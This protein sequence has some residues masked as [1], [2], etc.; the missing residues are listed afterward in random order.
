MRR[1]KKSLAL[2]LVVA[3]V[4]TSIPVSAAPTRAGSYTNSWFGNFW[5]N[6]FNWNWNNNWNDSSDDEV[7]EEPETEV[8]E[9]QELVVVEDATT[10]EN[11]DMLRASTYSLETA[12][13]SEAAA[14]YAVATAAEEGTTDDT[15]EDST[16]LKYFPVTMY[17]YDQATINNAT[18]QVEVDSGKE[19]TEWEGI[20]FS[21]GSPVA[22]SY[23]TGSS[24]KVIP[25]F[26]ED[27]NAVIEDG[28][29]L[30]VSRQ[31]NYIAIGSDSGIAASPNW[32]KDAL[33]HI[34]RTNNE[35]TIQNAAGHY[36]VI[37]GYGTRKCKT[38]ENSNNKIS[39]VRFS[40]DGS[41][42][43]AIMLKSGSFFLKQW[44]G[45]TGKNFGGSLSA[46]D[47]G[48]VFYL[49]KIIEDY[50]TTDV[51]PYA[52]WN[53][54]NKNSGD[55]NNGQKIYSG[56]AESKLDPNKDIVFTKPDG[57]IFNSDASVKNI[58]TNVEM[59][60]VY[61]NGTYT[62]DASKNGVYFH[63]DETQGSSGK[64]ASNTRLYF[65]KNTP[66]WHYGMNYGDGSTNMWIPFNDGIAIHQADVDYHFGMRTTI[67]FSMTENGRM[68]VNDPES[69]PIQF[70]FSGDDDVWV[71]IDGQLVADLGG[72][73]NRLDA[74]IDF[75]ANTITLS[76]DN[77]AKTTVNGV[78]QNVPFGDYNNS[79]TAVDTDGD[80]VV[81]SYTT[82]LFT[83]AEGIGVITQDIKTFAA[84]TSHE[85]TIFYLERGE[86]S[87]NCKIEFNLPMKDTVTVTKRADRSKTDTKDE[88]G[89]I[90]GTEI[91]SLTA[92]EQAIIDE[93]DFGFTIYKTAVGSAE[94]TAWANAKYYLMNA[95][96]QVVA[97]LTTDANGHFTLKNGQSAR[98]VG[99]IT[100]G[101]EYQVIEDDV[102]GFGFK[103]PTFTYS[104]EA[105]DG[106]TYTI[107][108]TQ[109]TKQATIP[110]TESSHTSTAV[111]AAG[112]DEAEDSLYIVCENFVDADLPNPSC[113]PVDD[114]LVVDYGL[115]VEINVLGND[116]YR[117]DSIEIKD[118]SD[119][120]FGTVSIVDNKLV[121]QLKEQ[122]T[123]AEVLTYTAEVT[124]S[125]TDAAG[126]KLESSKTA[127]AKVYIMPATIMYYEEDF[128]TDGNKMVIYTDGSSSG[129]EQVGTS[130]TDKQETGWVG[131]VSDSPYGSDV[132]YLN[133]SGD[134]NGSSMYVDT[135]NGAAQFSYEF[136]GT[137]T[138]FFA[139]TTN[140]SGYMRITVSQNGSV[141]Y[142]AYRDT[143]YKTED[144]NTT[145]Y[146]IPVFTYA[147][148]EYG[149]Y[150]VTVTIA[151][152][153]NSKDFGKEFWLDGIRV[154]NPLD[155]TP[156]Y[157]DNATEEEKALVTRVENAYIS[158]EEAYMSN[159]TL[160]LKL[161]NDSTILDEEGNINWTEDNG[162][163]VFTDTNGEILDAAEYESN[164]PKEEVY[165]NERQSVTFSM[166]EWD[167]N[168]NKIYLGIKAPFGTGTVS[169]N[170]H[171]LNINNATDCYY[172]ITA[173][174]NITTDSEGVVTATFKVEATSGLISVTNIKVS[175]DFVF[176]I[177]KGTDEEC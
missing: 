154:F 84:T 112:S 61:K 117:G 58:Y 170:G 129:W 76:A 115:P 73:H 69:D 164:G 15:A 44:G 106:Y 22:E 135:T 26:D 7:V 43:A 139:R 24:E 162:F 152:G 128:G 159:T 20:Y 28:Y 12:D 59:P 75:A 55:N 102:V 36:M 33:W 105:A 100:N 132:A 141:I 146:N 81:D 165:L 174:A 98:F 177:I 150:K 142:T 37:G 83:D 169:I 35:Y 91:T 127:T 87:S 31:S 133:D 23:A 160:R 130:Q 79:F 120:E 90:T 70:S 3:M 109:Y 56:L 25:T 39:I 173:Y 122:L 121:Y 4:L 5:N 30:I 6:L 110:S 163:V 80:G 103:E 17:N 111:I 1:G 78:E 63:E 116:L 167:T 118:V 107:G 18:H 67:P 77:S 21:G 60:F 13:V 71:F 10:V 27:G 57:G 72:I 148:A 86:G 99:E 94:K 93:I 64:A 51:L 8:S 40:S 29:Y 9:E 140:N 62:F 155:T 95:N 47:I 104:G 11:G 49:Y 157:D 48:N 97:N 65:N 34:K 125:T 134:S 19:L 176:T 153:A 2:M 14:T 131:D 137:G 126:T 151:G 172:D 85:L 108:D 149:T 53:W 38:E 42:N 46:R 166:T 96:G 144:A 168:A 114:T 138:S 171:T 101:Y 92:A 89:N 41:D 16:V 66:Q 147:D 50:T 145:L 119:G 54:W 175:G 113:F 123:K 32:T 45:A 156:L 52:S 136:T 88:D 124:S 143:S 158:D 74:D 82:K 161:L 68:S